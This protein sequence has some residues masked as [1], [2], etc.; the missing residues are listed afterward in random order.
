VADRFYVP[1]CRRAV[2]D[3]GNTGFDPVTKN[4]H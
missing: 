3:N 2:T 4:S 1:I